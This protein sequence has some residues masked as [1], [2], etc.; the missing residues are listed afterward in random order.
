MIRDEEARLYLG[1]LAAASLVLVVSSGRRASPAGEAAFRHGVFQV[2]S[3]MTTT[4]FA[5]VDFI[6]WPALALMILIF[7]M[8]I[9]GSAGSTGGSVKVVRHLLLGKILRRS[10]ARRC[11][12]RR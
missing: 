8:L 12:P 9:G 2:V 11:I 10:C 7:V 1:I 6:G 3:M 5:S 4:G